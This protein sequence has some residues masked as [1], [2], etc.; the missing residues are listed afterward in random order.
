MTTSSATVVRAGLALF[1]SA[2]V[3][4]TGA[5]ASGSIA[6]AQPAQAAAPAQAATT[7]VAT[8]GGHGDHRGNHRKGHHHGDKATTAR[9]GVTF[10]VECVDDNRVQRPSTFTLA[11]ADDN[12][13]L[14]K[15]DW[16]NWGADNAFATGVVRENVSEPMSKGDKWISY[17][18]RV[19][20][21]NIVEGEASATYTKLIV[22]TVGKA[23]QGVDALQIF[24]LPGNK[25]GD[26]GSGE[27]F[28]DGHE[29]MSED[30]VA[31]P[32]A[33]FMAEC[34]TDNRVRKPVNFTIACADGNQSLHKLTWKNW[35]ETQATATGIVRENVSEPMSKGDRYITYPVRVT[36][37]NLVKGEAT[38]TY[39][40][41]TVRVVG[42]APKGVERVQV[43]DLPG[44]D[45]AESGSMN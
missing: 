42:Q 29:G 28:S 32:E 11:C 37:S 24:D 16:K 10:L 22:R 45:P 41:L 9:A 31:T 3:L 5:L 39:N 27:D 26:N 36:A 20:A 21:T 18:V 17:P 35:G 8:H 15:L 2:A 33:T 6:T 14:T 30:H 44:N 25:A 23:P 34:L 4:A 13:R 40:K 12:Q 7:S 38:M 1:G 19:K 43:F